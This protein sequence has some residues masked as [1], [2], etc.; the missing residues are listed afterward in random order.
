MTDFTKMTG[1]ELCDWLQ[2]YD[3]FKNC[4]DDEIINRARYDDEISLWNL[5]ACAWAARKWCIVNNL[6]DDFWDN[7]QQLSTPKRPNCILWPMCFD[8]TDWLRAAAMVIQQI[9]EGK[10]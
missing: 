8:E 4:D 10:K 6:W 2:D 9:E 7:V 5:A 3:V 1:Q